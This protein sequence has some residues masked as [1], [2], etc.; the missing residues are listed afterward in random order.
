MAPGRQPRPRSVQGPRASH[1][2][3]PR[4]AGPL[5]RD[6]PELRLRERTKPLAP[7]HDGTAPNKVP[8]NSCSL[9]RTSPSVRLG[10]RPGSRLLRTDVLSMGVRC[11][12]ASWSSCGPSHKAARRVH[13]WPLCKVHR[14]L[15]SEW[16]S[17]GTCEAQMPAPA[18]PNWA[19]A[20]ETPRFDVKFAAPDLG[21]LWHEPCLSNALTSPFKIGDGVELDLQPHR[22]ALTPLSPSQ[23]LGGGPWPGREIRAGSCCWA[24][25]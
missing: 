9:W 3:G 1:G 15:S 19:P 25:E 5:A 23:A 24:V 2:L 11:G 10:P 16:G 12:M 17:R 7:A 8:I 14:S 6:L 13:D 18:L 4:P 20:P 22:I 21:E